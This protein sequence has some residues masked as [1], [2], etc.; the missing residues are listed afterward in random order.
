MQLINKISDF[1]SKYMAI[2]VFIVAVVA[3][4]YPKTS[5]WIQTSWINYL[6][7]V[8]MFG[9]GLTL[10]LDDFVLILTRPKDVLIG[11]F[12][13]FII[14]PLLAFVLSRMFHLD[15]ALMAG[16]IL[17]GACP[18]GT[19]SNVITYISKGDV[20]LSV[21]MT[22]INT[23]LAPILTP[24]ITFIFLQTTIEVDIVAMFIGILNVILVPIILGFILNK[25]FYKITQKIVK[26]LP[27]ISVI[28]ICLIIA[29][30]VSHNAEKI[31]TSGMVILTVVIIHNL[32]GC[33]SGFTLGKILRLNPAKTKALSIEIGMQNSGLATS[34]A[35]TAFSNLAAATVPGAIFSVWHNISGA[36]L[37]AIYRKWDDKKEENA[38]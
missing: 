19:A 24:L 7:M 38:D 21:C 3:L 11:C 16:V 1:F 14:M 20:A 30:V 8:I 37:S 23:L 13:Q 35:N 9:M 10:K 34:L 22:S 18:G 29:S 15:A 4:L 25:F 32:L 2:F 27:S 6:L 28:G 36:I 17:V 33:L 5:L 31:Y 12:A 26:I